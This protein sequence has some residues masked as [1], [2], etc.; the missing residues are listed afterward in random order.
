MLSIGGAHGTWAPP[1]AP[2]DAGQQALALGRALA[3][4]HSQ[5]GTAEG[6]AGPD[7]I[8]TDFLGL[9]DCLISLSRID[10]AGRLA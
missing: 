6:Q 8:L 7:R 1:N 4:L 2:L 9:P 3:I 5:H 10:Q